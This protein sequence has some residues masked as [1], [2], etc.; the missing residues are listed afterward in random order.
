M[1]CPNFRNFEHVRTFSTDSLGTKIMDNFKFNQAKSFIATDINRELSLAK[2]S[3]SLWKKTILKA[4]GISPGG[5]NFLAALCLLSYTEFAG[6]VLNN[7][8]SDSNSRTNFDSFFNS[9]GSEYKAFNES[10]NVYKIFRC[11]LAHEY[12]VKK[13]CVIA[14][15]SIKKG[16]GIRWDGKHYYFILDA[17]YSDF[18]KKLSEL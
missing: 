9:I 13:S 15:T 4:L 6:R 5:G 12:Y 11:G 3:Q 18:M 7:D 14:I 17:Y 1:G 16:I 10:H 2:A 8:F